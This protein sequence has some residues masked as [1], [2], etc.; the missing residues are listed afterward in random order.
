MTTTTIDPPPKDL[1]FAGLLESSLQQ[2]PSHQR[3][4]IGPPEEFREVI[5]AKKK[6][7]TVFRSDFYRI[8]AQGDF[9]GVHIFSPVIEIV[10]LFFFP[11]HSLRLPVFAMEFV[12]IGPR[13]VVGVID[14]KGHDD[15]QSSQKI[16]RSILGAA[17]RTFPHLTN[18][19][20]PPAWYAEARSGD[21]FFVRPESLAEFQ[22]LIRC[23]HF[24][25]QQYAGHASDA[26]PEKKASPERSNFLRYY[27]DHHRDN[28]PGIPFLNR[29]FGE[30][31]TA[32]FLRDHLFS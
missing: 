11:N 24:V 20:D 31:W 15:D 2:F 1:L 6:G 21:D 32:T 4:A 12:R 30:D 19:E 26:S 16:A 17:H 8:G 25:W 27:K 14:C 7:S 5:I 29:V 9:R 13:G 3:T 23:H 22:E 10:N 18:G 28:S